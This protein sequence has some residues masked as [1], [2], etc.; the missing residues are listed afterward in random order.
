MALR[1]PTCSSM[2]PR[3]DRRAEQHGADAVCVEEFAHAAGGR[4]RARHD[5]GAVG[6]GTTKHGGGPLHVAVGVFGVIEEPAVVRRHD[7]GASSRR[8]DVV[9]AVHH[10]GA[11]EPTIDRRRAVGP[12]AHRERCRQREPPLGCA[13]PR[14]GA[15]HV[16]L[17]VEPIACGECVGCPGHGVA[18]SGS[19]AVGRPRVDCHSY[20]VVGDRICE[21][22]AGCRW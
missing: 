14:S 22:A 18:D 10:V 9:G 7:A 1:T 4:V 11:P 15:G 17:Q 3:R 2:P 12:H 13:N 21:V 6:D 20:H 5:V 16:R 8:H 19:P